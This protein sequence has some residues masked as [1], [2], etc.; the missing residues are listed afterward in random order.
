MSE[1]YLAQINIAKMKAPLDSPLMKEFNDFID[2][3]NLL[4]EDSPG[5][6]WR[7]KDE[8]GDSFAGGHPLLQDDM[9]LIN[10][11]VWKDI[12]SLKQFSFQTV[13]SYFVKSRSKWFDKMDKPYLAMWWVE[14]DHYPTVEEAVEK[15]RCIE[16]NGPTEEAFN[17][18]KVF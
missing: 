8:N 4:A 7:L 12:E 18:S 6:V 3:I 15:L 14:K 11:S 10:M 16:S 5:F 1:K 13:H 2:P 9:M 17:F